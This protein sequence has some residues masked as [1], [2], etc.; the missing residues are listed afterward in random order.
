MNFEE[1]F[2]FWNKLTDLEKEEVSNACFTEQYDKGMQ[3][4]RSE[5]TCKGLLTVE[6]GKMRVYTVSK[7]GREVTLFTVGDNEVCVL[8]ASCLMD[9]I[10]FDVIIEAAEATDVVIMP[11]TCLNKLMNS[12]IYVELF[13]YK[14]ATE[15]FTDVMWTIQQILFQNMDQRVAKYIWDEYCATESTTLLTTHDE[16]ARYVG[17][18]REVV[19]RILK[20]I[21]EDNSIELGRGKITILE[22]EIL[23]KRVESD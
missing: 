2:P 11:I 22:P 16:I 21:A 18:S 9:S 19:T 14:R 17:S 3:M 20:N 15:K 4:R 5:E 23:K 1:L 7:E 13:M 12:N 10:Q 8:S 6:T